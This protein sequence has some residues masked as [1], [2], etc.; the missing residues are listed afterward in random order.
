MFLTEDIKKYINSIIKNRVLTSL[1]SNEFQQLI[2]IYFMLIEDIYN[3]LLITDRNDTP[4]QQVI[5]DTAFF[6][7]LKRNKDRDFIAILYLLLP[8]IDDKN[9]YEKFRMIKELSDITTL[10]N[11]K[12]YAIN[13]FQY[14]RGYMEDKKYN[15][16]KFS[17]KDIETNFKLLSQS[18]DR[19]K[20][21]LYVNWVNI[22][23]VLTTDFHNTKIYKNSIEYYNTEIPKNRN[24]NAVY[25]KIAARSLPKG[26]LFDTIVNDLYLTTIDF[27]WLLFE[28]TI[29]G[30]N[31]MYIDILNEIYPIYDILNNKI[32]SKWILLDESKQRRFTQNM[33]L[34][35]MKAEKNESYNNIPSEILNDFFISMLLYFDTKYKYVSE[36]IEKTK[37]PL[38]KK[39]SYQKIRNVE[40]NDVE[41]DDEQDYDNTEISKEMANYKKIDKFYLYDFI[42]SQLLLL[43]KTWYGFKMFRNG[44]IVR[45]ND[46]ITSATPKLDCNDKTTFINNAEHNYNIQNIPLYGQQIDISY[47]NIYNF[48]KLIYLINRINYEDKKTNKVFEEKNYNYLITP[49]HYDSMSKRNRD[50]FDMILF[51][52]KKIK[53]NTLEDTDIKYIKRKFSI[54]NN[55]RMKY[56]FYNFTDEQIDNIN[57]EIIKSIA[58]NIFDIVFECLSKR[59]L[60][61]EFKI[62][63]KDFEKSVLNERSRIDIKFIQDKFYNH[64]KKY[65]KAYYYLTDYRYENLDNIVDER[66]NKK[67]SYLKRVSFSAR[68]YN[69]Y[70][71]DWISQ[72]NFFH[73]FINQRIVMLT[74]GTGVGKSSQVPKLLLYGLKAFDKKFDGKV[75]CTQPRINATVGNTKNISD[76]LGVN[77]ETYHPYYKKPLKTLNGYVQYKYEA[78]SHIDEDINYFLRIVTDGSLLTELKDSPLLKQAVSSQRNKFDNSESKFYSIKNIYDIVIVDE[79]HEHNQ[80]MDIILSMIRGTLLI[81]NQIKLYI[82]SATMDADDPIYRKYYRCINDNLKYPIRDLYDYREIDV[83]YQLLDRIVLDRRIHISPPEET[84][85]FKI[86]EIYND[87]DL[88]EEDSYKLAIN[89]AK[90]ICTNNIPSVYSDILL[91]C[92]TVNKI[93]KLVEELNKVISSDTIAIPYYTTLPEETKDLLINNLN[94][95][96]KNYKFD[97]KYII[98]VVEKKKTFESV[99]TDFKY[100]RVIF[101][102]TNIAEASI[103]INSLGFVID[104][105]YNNDVSYNYES[106]T[107]NINIIPISEASRL[108]RKG[109]VGRIA[110]GTVY[111]TYKQ[112]SRLNVIPTYNICK[113][114]FSDK[115]LE[116]V[117][118]NPIES[119]FLYEDYPFFDTDNKNIRIQTNQ[120][121]LAYNLKLDIIERDIKNKNETTIQLLYKCYYKILIFQYCNITEINT[122]SIYTPELFNIPLID[123]DYYDYVVPFSSSGILVSALIDSKLMFHLIHPLEDK[124]S[125]YR[126]PE[127]R[128][129]KIED[130][131]KEKDIN[132]M[133]KNIILFEPQ[134]NLYLYEYKDFLYK[135]KDVDY[136]SKIKMKTDKLLELNLMHPI[137]VSYK[138]GVFENVLFIVYFLKKTSFNLMSI[139][140]DNEKFMKIFSSKQSDLLV[141]N[142]IY[143][144]FKSTHTHILFNENIEREI[145]KSY[146]IFINNFKKYKNQYFSILDK[147]SYNDVI[148]YI[149]KNESIENIKEEMSEN[150]SNN[151]K[152]IIKDYILNEISEWCKIYGI[153]YKVFIGIL[154][155]F[156]EK[157][158][159]YTYKLNK[160]EYNSYIK[161]SLIENELDVDKNII[162]S[163]MY[164]NISNIFLIDEN[165]YKNAIKFDSPIIY[166]R[167]SFNKKWIS[168]VVNNRFLLVLSREN[169]FKNKI[170]IIDIE[171]ETDNSIV[172]IN[173][174]SSVDNKL[175]SSIVYF[176]DNPTNKE[177]IKVNSIYHNFICNDPI[178][179]ENLKNPKDPKFAE[180]LN[181]LQ[182]SMKKYKDNNC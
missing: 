160:P 62:R 98:D 33:D 5:S 52:I 126:T 119:T 135:T 175:Y 49:R 32:E 154:N 66:S 130:Y 43:E 110:S 113:V 54:R 142:K 99:N 177:F 78:D 124:I 118:E 137:V 44:R 13:N 39:N 105:G 152:L 178:N 122:N 145:D 87:T 55:L 164:G 146:E 80:N 29:N 56:N 143:E 77:I 19:I 114:N 84:T 168:K 41:I 40:L 53:D 25:E 139:V 100:E 95:V 3:K 79:S 91:F 31:I 147:D 138:L 64:I 74:G 136:L 155:E 30:Q 7:Q 125:E 28:I 106:N 94:Y 151:N 70:A 38:N 24:E 75:I 85:I 176:R 167:N 10:K 17:I 174:L 116:L 96:K 82:V 71:M 128:R 158:L 23:P 48:S 123:Q 69:F 14:S 81:N 88:N 157:L 107:A 149:I 97:R 21:K 60:L 18:I 9:N 46:Y 117:S 121:I 42:R 165:R 8:F 182:I 162:K 15:E 12:E 111:Y 67:S 140:D 101:V 180:Y 51:L 16:Y 173:I 22:V 47:K 65:D 156:R 63:D 148:K 61:S 50:N 129:L 86:N 4:E 27:K 11:G 134:S 115:L 35:F 133:I 58:F 72:I 93:K 109:R 37:D 181:S 104:T 103:T 132:K 6:E 170:E 127:T 68:W 172:N 90:E 83:P 2:D 153:N 45:L 36:V 73:H 169:E 26:E 89:I 34:F 141:I 76:E 1:N 150:S 161:N 120:K 131:S 163:F 108:Q 144:L 159:M 166:K 92:P 59:G 179:I 102:S 20:T 171:E 57:V 112:N